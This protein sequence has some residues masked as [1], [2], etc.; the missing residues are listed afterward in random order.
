[1]ATKTDIVSLKWVIGLMNK[2]G[3]NAEQALVEYSKDPGQKKPLLQ[4]MW[5]I[6]QITSTLR[7]LGM[8][9]GEL[10]TIEM[11][12]SL[13]F[14]Y[15]D[16]VIGERRK[17]TMGG[18]MQALK[19]LPAYFAHTQ[20]VRQDTGQG[21]EQYVNDLRRWVGER[22]RPQAFFFHMDIPPAQGIT[23]GA[24]PASDEEIKSRANVMLALYLQMAK[25]A[26]RK[27]NVGE[28]MKTVARISRKMQTL[29]VGT[30]PERFWFTQ[31]GLCEGIAG[32]LIIP[33]ECIAQIFK[34]GAFL[35]KYAR[36]NGAQVDSSVD[37]DGVL[38]QMLYYIASCKSKPVHIAGIRE[39]F[40][41]DDDTLASSN[42]GLV[43]IDALVT[44]LSSALEQL[45][46]VVN[47]IGSNDLSITVADNGAGAKALE[48]LENAQ[49]RLSAAGQGVHAD[50]LE[51]VNAKLT[52]LYAGDFGENQALKQQTINEI[53]R[54][55][56]DVKLD[57]EYKLEYGLC[58]SFSSKEFELRES[59][60]SATFTQMS[61]VENHLHV[62]LRRKALASAL[63]KKPF[64]DESV[65]QL[66]LALH[67]YLNKSDQGHDELRKALW[68]ADN[69]EAD[70]DLLFELAQTFMEQLPDTPERN[71]IGHSLQLLGEIS[72]A[73]GFA[74]MEREAAVIDQC[75]DWLLA[76][77]KAGC[78]REDEAFR[79]FA[80]AFAQIELHLQRSII[81]P[82]DDTSHMM[83]FAEQRAGELK[84]YSE[85]LSCGAAV[86]EPAALAQR[87]YVN[88]GVIP[89]EFR[90]VFIEESTDIA[91]ELNQ[92]VVTWL[93]E[94]E[95][96]N[97]LRDI[98]R[99]FHTFKG[100]GRAVG[101]NTLGELGWAAQDLL[102]RVIDGELAPDDKLQALVEDVVRALPELVA[103]FGKIEGFNLPVTRELT[104]RCFLLANSSGEDIAEDLQSFD[105]ATAVSSAG[106]SAVTQTIGQ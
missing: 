2:Q 28:S 13:N 86:I 77:S 92:L 105:T 55:I 40:G 4:C 43:H 71:A 45:N 65:M 82:L 60:V 32:G 63:V 84:A 41:I 96:N 11:E 78:V 99:H 24:A 49:I 53:V 38:E 90:E 15:K 12:R 3:E 62:V 98:R 25:S 39:V 18:L 9:K 91:A 94:P 34:T 106:E 83:A 58:S 100:N 76:A 69:G 22:P 36:E 66:T 1:M 103:S 85:D 57:L 27:R 75:R 87:L 72:G 52:K 31:V 101:A 51:V 42:S 68:D 14:L 5:A 102:D 33:D 54:G 16:K 8:K 97:T 7:A 44:A 50:S 64:G 20:N 47:L 17:L 80:D 48:G 74:N 21:L 79:C 10:L 35:I 88:D 19:V 56:V 26:L 30:E 73:L 67:R 95:V 104:N 23:E 29:F 81:D 46:A 61:L 59:V 37:Y 70:I 89:A 93:A 6:H